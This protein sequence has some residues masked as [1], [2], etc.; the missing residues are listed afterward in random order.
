MDI[1]T[2]RRC[3]SRLDRHAFASFVTDIFE[4]SAERRGT[5]ERFLPLEAA[6]EDVFYMPCRD[7][8]G[9]SIH[10]VFLLH[11]PPLELFRP[12]SNL[13]MRD[14]LLVKR[15]AKIRGIYN[16]Q[17]GYWGMVSPELRRA[18]A[19]SSI[20]FVTNLCG[21]EKTVYQDMLI[22]AYQRLKRYCGLKR[23][24]IFVG[25]CDSFIET[26]GE[27][28]VAVFESFAQRHNDG[29]AITLSRNE[30]A[31]AA[32]AAE[33]HLSGVMTTGALPYEPIFVRAAVEQRA[34][35]AEFDGLLRG[36]SLETR[37][38]EFLTTNYK[39]LFGSKY[40]RI[41]TQLWLRC[42]ELDF[43]DRAR[44]IDIFLRNSVANDWHLFEIKRAVPLTRTIRD[45]PVISHHVVEAI[46]QIKNYARLLSKDRIKSHFAD[47]GIE[48]FEP[49]LTVVIGRTPQ[50]PFEQWR[51]V[52]SE[53]EG[54]VSIVTFDELR[55]ELVSRLEDRYALME[56]FSAA[57]RSVATP[58]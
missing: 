29:I 31:V 17:T 56:S 37:L 50:I 16:G 4:E 27:R 54:R 57:G 45:V 2:L 20:A 35:L 47:R 44:R 46:H 9:G 36:S 21:M 13:D 25:S 19:L 41:E 34:L 53:N 15:L 3:V 43:G 8:Y 52:K 38:E 14:P 39:E 11:F 7:S 26:M 24:E 23:P 40:D 58:S 22:P 51:W 49:C 5:Y 12:S 33:R 10:S 55:G 30:P 48:Y 42:P 18:D 6:G 32:F 1:N 28:A